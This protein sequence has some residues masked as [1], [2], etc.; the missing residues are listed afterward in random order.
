MKNRKT[1]IFVNILLFLSVIIGLIPTEIMPVY[2]HYFFGLL[3]AVLF[4][5]HIFLN[6]KWCVT[7]T[8][9]LISGKPNQKA[10]RQYCT[11]LLLLI[12]WILVILS[13]FSA[14][15]YA[16][17]YGNEFIIYKHAHVVFSRIGSL[18]I[19]IHLYQHKGQIRSYFKKINGKAPPR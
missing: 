1:K 7:M 12:L 8:K 6:R 11:D 13:G 2:T 5:I 4:L 16:M 19:L 17:G 9:A 18:V 14:M 3:F 15:G 10:K